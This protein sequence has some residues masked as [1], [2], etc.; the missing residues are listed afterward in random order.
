M[1]IIE[2]VCIASIRPSIILLLPVYRF[3]L[4][5]CGLVACEQEQETREK[6]QIGSVW[7]RK[8]GLIIFVKFYHKTIIYWGVLKFRKKKKVRKR[9]SVKFDNK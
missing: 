4:L 7:K 5:L 6:N 2:V 8:R 1:I 3:F 9:E